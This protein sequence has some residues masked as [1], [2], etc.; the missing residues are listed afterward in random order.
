MRSAEL[1]GQPLCFPFSST[2]TG[3][4]FLSNYHSCLATGCA[5][6]VNRDTLLQ[7]LINVGSTLPYP[8]NMQYTRMVYTGEARPDNYKAVMKRLQETSLSSLLANGFSANI[9]KNLLFSNRSRS[10][11]YFS[12]NGGD[13]GSPFNPTNLYP[14]FSFD[15][16]TLFQMLMEGGSLST[17]NLNIFSQT[18][19]NIC[20][21]S[22][23]QL[24]YPGLP[25]L[26]GSFEGCCDKPLCYIPKVELYSPYSGISSY[27]SQWSVWNECSRSCGS[28][29]KNRTRACIGDN[30]NSN[31]LLFQTQLCNEQECPYYTHWGAWGE[32][33][34]TC[35][36]GYRSR[37]R[38]CSV[39]GACVGGDTES[40]ICRFG[41]C[42]KYEYSNWSPCSNACGK[43]M[44]T[45]SRYCVHEGAYGCTNTTNDEQRCEQFCGKS[46]VQCNTS[47]CCYEQTCLQ[48]D[49]SPGYCETDSRAGSPC[50]IGFCFFRYGRQQCNNGFSLLPHSLSL[51]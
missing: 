12:N 46:T 43:G 39:S 8:A 20:P 1:Y 19:Y 7:Q 31:A 15:E 2:A 47:T 45:R 21:Y 22:P 25:S 5:V 50:R 11:P 33:S 37:S 28:G 48:E 24:N 49:G 17:Q 34:V 30:C 6:N 41:D 44:R 4:E 32:C 42:P 23:Q 3:H 27:L 18:N 38:V 51:T 9:F 14:N 29:L 10:F 35:G 16:N 13:A 40:S 36:G 26:S